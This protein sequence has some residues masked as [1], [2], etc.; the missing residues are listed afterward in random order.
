MGSNYWGVKE[1]SKKAY[2][3]EFKKIV[4][5]A[6][7]V[8]EVL[9]ARDP[10][11]SRCIDIEKKI[12]QKDPNKKIILVLNKIDLVPRD[13]VTQW[14]KYL[15]NEYPTIAF[16]CTTQEQRK[17]LGQNN[18][19]STDVAPKSLLQSSDCL[20]AD[21]L[22]QLLKNY[23]RNLKIKTSISVGIIGYPN[24]GKSSLINSLKRTKAVG[25]GATPGFTK[26]A[27]V[28]YILIAYIDFSRKFI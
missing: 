4:E 17:K 7:V 21:I 10:L 27:Q 24:V 8:L 20:G 16:K 13:N 3:R 12:L 6:D 28:R 2:Y 15:R 14:L 26:V 9:D 5:V 23:C 19:I 22:I 11:G 18:A 1:G 25:V